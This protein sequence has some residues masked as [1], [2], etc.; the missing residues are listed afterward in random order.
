M[1]RCL[2]NN[3]T[4]WYLS[5]RDNKYDFASTFSYSEKEVLAL[6]YF[7]SWLSGFIEAEACFSKRQN[8]NHSFSI[9]Q[10]NDQFLLIAIGTYFNASNKI[11][12][13]PSNFY[14]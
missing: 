13:L 1:K 2:L 7:P 9:G 10:K 11:R 12:T 3:D 6:D 8:N 14:T 4:N 5:N